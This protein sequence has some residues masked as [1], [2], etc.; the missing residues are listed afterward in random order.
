MTLPALQ[1]GVFYRRILSQFPQDISLAFAYG[2]GV[3]KQHGTSQGQ[4]DKN[5][6]DFV[7]AVDDPVTW[8]TMNLL[9]NRKHYSILK[10]LGPTMISSVQNEHGAS[11]YYNTLVPV[12][13]RIIKYGVISTESLIDDLMH[14]KTMYVAGRLHKP[15]K[16]LVQSENGK[17]RA[18]LVANLK[19][20]VTASFLMLPESFTEEDLFLQIAGLSY[21][22]DFRMVIGEDKSKVANIVKDNIQHF[23]IL[24]S[25][26]LRDCPQVV[27]KPQQ[28]KLEQRITKLVDPPGKNRDV[29]EILLQVAQDPDCGAVVQQ[30]I[31]SIVKSSSIT[32]SVK[33]IAT[34]GLWKT[35]SYSSKKLI[36]MWR[37]WRRKPSASQMS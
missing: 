6:L 25:N 13:G 22:G 16:M 27:Y 1:T 18:A 30:G 15:V 20:A 17:L 5:M 14:W 11:V 12:D 26:I 32:Q 19:S 9:Q 36:K 24:Y 7:F 3:F 33:G 4:M 31:S 21:A 29:E 23:R 37:G 34:A 35:V 28:G 10:L 2:S 8:H